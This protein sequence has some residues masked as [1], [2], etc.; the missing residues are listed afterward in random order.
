MGKTVKIG[1]AFNFELGPGFN[2]EKAK[3]GPVFNFT[4]WMDVYIY[5]HMCVS[6]YFLGKLIGCPP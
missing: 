2:F 1:P 5:I 6:I 4:E 3:I